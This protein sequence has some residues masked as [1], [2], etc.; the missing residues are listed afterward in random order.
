MRVR[1]YV[2][3]V[4]RIMF[5]KRTKL[6]IINGFGGIGDMFRLIVTRTLL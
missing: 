2:Y 5:W 1:V 3:I 4:P 6:K